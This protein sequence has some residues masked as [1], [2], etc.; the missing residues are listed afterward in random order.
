MTERTQAHTDWTVPAWH[1]RAKCAKASDPTEWDMEGRE[2][3]GV[4]LQ[5]AQRSCSG[6]PVIAECAGEALDERPIGVVRAGIPIPMHPSRTVDAGLKMIARGINPSR[7]V[8][9]AMCS[10]H[11]QYAAAVPYLMAAAVDRVADRV[12]P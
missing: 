1:E 10:P 11:S 12:T 8:L 6:C 5:Q 9:E 7:A 2:S 3:P 4:R